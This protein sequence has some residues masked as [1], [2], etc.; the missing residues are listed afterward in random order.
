M[1]SHDRCG[2][3]WDRWFQEFLTKMAYHPPKFPTEH[4]TEQLLE[5]AER[6]ASPTQIRKGAL[7][8]GV[9]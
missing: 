3:V 9:R 1:R 5:L 2:H 8:E 7:A 6:I 4:Q